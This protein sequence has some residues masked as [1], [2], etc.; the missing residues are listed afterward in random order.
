MIAIDIPGDKKLKLKYL[1]LDFN[2]TL[3][4]EGKLIHLVKEK[5]NRLSKCLKIYIL[6]ADTFEKKKKQMNTLKCKLH[7]IKSKNQKLE[8]DRFIDKLGYKNVIAIGNGNNDCLMVKNA[9]L[10]ICLLQ[11]EGCAVQTLLNSDILSK[12]IND[13]LNMLLNQKI[14]TA[15]LRK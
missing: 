9:A 11:K 12:N 2:G 5:I 13:A 4:E 14:I 6:T 8:K 15:T 1:V 7:I 3:A 10:G